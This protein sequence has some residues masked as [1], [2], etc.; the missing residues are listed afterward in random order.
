PSYTLHCTAT[1]DTSTLSLHDA[2]PICAPGRSGLLRPVLHAERRHLAAGGS[3][4][5]RGHV[6]V[7]EPHVRPEV[8]EFDFLA[9]DF[10]LLRL[11]RSEE[12]TSELKSPDHLVCRI[13]LATK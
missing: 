4:R 13:L 11:R 12:H 2:L 1:T 8:I 5:H 9:A 6:G 7:P 3:R 10:E